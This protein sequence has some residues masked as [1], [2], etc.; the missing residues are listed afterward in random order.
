MKFSLEDTKET[1]LADFKRREEAFQESLMLTKPKKPYLCGGIM[2][3]IKKHEQ[4][5][6]L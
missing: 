5:R 2:E 6:V 4:H 1:L 3:Q